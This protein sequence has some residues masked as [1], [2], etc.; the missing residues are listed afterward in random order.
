MFE[1]FCRGG[2]K[3]GRK[4]NEKKRKHGI[5]ESPQTQEVGQYDHSEMITRDVREGTRLAGSGRER[6]QNAMMARGKKTSQREHE[7]L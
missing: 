4:D 7:L 1:I 5:T 3:S 2:T 6:E